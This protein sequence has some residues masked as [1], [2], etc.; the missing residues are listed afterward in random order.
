MLA[1]P[2]E[3]ALAHDAEA[4]E[5]DGEKGVRPLWISHMGSKIATMRAPY[6]EGLEAKIAAAASANT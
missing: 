1:Q 4:D 3:H 5:P 6:R 2:R